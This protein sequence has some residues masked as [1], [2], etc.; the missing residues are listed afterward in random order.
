MRENNPLSGTREAV[1]S[2]VRVAMAKKRM[3]GRALAD[4]IG[5]PQSNFSRRITGDIAFD[6]DELAAI[7][8]VL[9]EPMATFVADASSAGAA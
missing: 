9:D 6:V 5:M 2:A 8:R 1:A 4:L 7:G 3:S